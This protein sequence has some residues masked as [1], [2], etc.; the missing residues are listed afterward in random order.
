MTRGSFVTNS[1]LQS[2]NNLGL[3]LGTSSY[4]QAVSDYKKH[5]QMAKEQ[6]PKLI[7]E[8]SRESTAQ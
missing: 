3:G 2:P 7:V 1:N 6:R 4:K 8:D 5:I